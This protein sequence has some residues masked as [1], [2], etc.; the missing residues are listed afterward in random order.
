MNYFHVQYN[1]YYELTAGIFN[2]ILLLMLLSKF[3][4]RELSHVIFI[5]VVSILMLANFFEV[6][7]IVVTRATFGQPQWLINL[8]NSVTFVLALL[9]S[10]EAFFYIL[11]KMGITSHGRGNWLYWLNRSIFFAYVLVMIHNTFT[12][13]VVQYDKKLEQYVYGPIYLWVGYGAIFFCFIEAIICLY[14]NR[15]RLTR[16]QR[17]AFHLFYI[18]MVVGILLQ[19]YIKSVTMVALAVAS[20]GAYMVFFVVESYD[21]RQMAE[22]LSKLRETK[23]EAQKASRQKEHF[24]EEMA[25]ALQQPVEKIIEL[26]GEL[27]GGTQEA[28]VK[29]LSKQ[30][31]AATESLSY[32]IRDVLELS[33]EEE[34]FSLVEEKF[35]L[36]ELLSDLKVLVGK[37][38]RDKGLVF[39]IRR[40]QK[41]GTE[42][43]GDSMRIKQ[44]LLNLLNNAIKY[45]R[46]GMVELQ[47]ARQENGITFKV[48]DTG[49]GIREEDIPYLFEA[50]SRMDDE[51]NRHIEG[52]GLGLSIVKK[53]T[54][55]MG[56]TVQVESVYGEG[57]VFTL[58]LP[59]RRERAE[60]KILDTATGLKYCAQMKE[61][62]IEILKMF[63]EGAKRRKEILQNTAMQ[64]QV[65]DFTIEVHA[66]KSNAVN[67]G[68]LPL[69]KT[70]RALEILG[71][72]LRDEDAMT[73]EERKDGLAELVLQT[74]ELLV[75]YDKTIRCV[76]TYLGQR[77]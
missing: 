46:E 67:I 65:E 16:R 4:G 68:A 21:Y 9:L 20:L 14:W 41:E 13:I 26:N 71:K 47:V 54:E 61:M 11:A 48:A 30:M 74:K 12:G 31:H 62:Y 5:R 29:E 55:R 42:Y 63:V 66:L 28:Q 32:L 52:T 45:T 33:G 75:Q 50:Y 37:T 76:Y 64:E 51:K 15:K 17:Y 6:A 22:M 69:A 1:I 58:Y 59:L 38:A 3:R 43:Y 77:D 70:A 23:D 35:T 27:A 36:E 24:L 56:G 8:M 49:I 40:E 72:R 39:R 73:E 60:E 34:T 7:T 18:S 19:V 53:L 57:S 10:C 44:V 2:L 25:I